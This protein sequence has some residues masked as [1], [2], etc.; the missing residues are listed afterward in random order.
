MSINYTD[1]IHPQ[2]E[3]ARQNLEAVPGF[4]T[5]TKAFLEL[6]LEK[7]LHGLYM[8]EKIRLS[9]TQLP[10]IYKKLPPICE[11]FGIDEPEFYLE[12]NPMPNA[13]TTGDQQTFLVITSGLLDHLKDDEIQSVLAHECGHILCRHVFYHTMA[14]MLVMCADALD[15][16]GK[17][18][19]PVQL[20]L[21]YWSR[22]S[23]LSADRAEVVYMGTSK[24]A[25][26]AL[27]RLSGGPYRLTEKVNIDEYARQ[28]VAYEELQ[29]NNKWEKILQSLAVM[30]ADH[31]FSAVR[32]QE[33]LKWE[34]SKQ[35]AMLRT[36]M[37]LAESNETCVA[38]GRKIDPGCKFCRFCGAKQ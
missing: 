9:P 15:L 17:M 16:L 27:V 33:L 28:A 21:N 18:V 34:R 1:F 38:C 29:S 31:P 26:N 8:A 32:V 5:V 35:Y 2:D 10:D 4:Q 23:E 30:N 24:P 20:A 25:I 7:M 22:K 37:K 19:Y 3:A 36:V 12:M 11:K 6:G 13:Y 14:I